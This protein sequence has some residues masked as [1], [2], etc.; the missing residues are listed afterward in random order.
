MEIDSQLV[1]LPFSYYHTNSLLL[2]KLLA[3]R[4]VAYSSLVQVYNFVPDV[5]RQF[6]CLGH[7]GEI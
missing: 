7:Y 4:L 2:T 6:F 3:N 5:H 1:F